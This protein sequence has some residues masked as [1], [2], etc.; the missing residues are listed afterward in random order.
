M[1]R[2]RRGQAQIRNNFR[3]LHTLRIKV[4]THR[5][6]KLAL[7]ALLALLEREIHIQFRAELLAPGIKRGEGK[8]RFHSL[9]RLHQLHLAADCPTAGLIGRYQQLGRR[10][11]H[12][13]AIAG[14]G[15][16]IKV[17]KAHASF[18][19]IKLH[20]ALHRDVEA[21]C[22]GCVTADFQI[23]SG[24]GHRLGNKVDAISCPEFDLN[25]K[26]GLGALHI[27]R[28]FQLARHAAGDA[29]RRQL[30]A[31]EPDLRAGRIVPPADVG[32]LQADTFDIDLERFF[33][34]CRRL[35]ADFAIA[36]GQIIEVAMPVLEPF[37]IKLEPG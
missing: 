10:K 36:P 25:I 11:L 5:R 13:H 12:I 27:C 9:A 35:V 7:H 33:A 32:V 28:K 21:G 31:R 6:A 2:H 14:A 20:I 23:Q 34:R 17:R 29:R 30:H 19:R 8:F 22:S 1:P 15:G 24:Q 18:R 37:Q 4:D 3:Q 26:L 16:Q